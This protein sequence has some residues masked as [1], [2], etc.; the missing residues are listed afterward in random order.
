MMVLAADE[1][2]RLGS[3]CR[4]HPTAVFM[5]AGSQRIV[6]G[7]RIV[8]GMN[9]ALHGGVTVGSDTWIGHGAV[10]GEP[11]PGRTEDE[12]RSG[13]AMA[14][15]IG[16]E[17]VIGVGTVIH[18]GCEIGSGAHIGPHTLL[19]HGV[20][21]GSGARCGPGMHLTANTIVGEH[22]LIGAGV[23]TVDDRHLIWCDSGDDLSVAPAVFGAG[24]RIGTGA[25]VMAGVS[26]GRDALVGAGVVVTRDVLAAAV[27]FGISARRSQ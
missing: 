21:I 3:G 15:V 19:E 10:V 2:P 27:V 22:A 20:R 1:L 16:A 9:T 5:P 11:P 6:L 8:V 13:D 4:V 25:L 26:I 17:A 14:T 23:R 24:C 12:V 18:A 7:D